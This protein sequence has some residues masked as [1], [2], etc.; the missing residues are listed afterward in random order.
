MRICLLIVP[1]HGYGHGALSLTLPIRKDRKTNQYTTKVFMKTPLQPIK[2]L[3]DLGSP[4]SWVDCLKTYKPQSYKFYMCNPQHVCDSLGSSGTELY[5]S[6]DCSESG[7][8]LG[9]MK[10]NT[11]T[12]LIS[13]FA[14][15][16]EFV[17]LVKDKLAIL[18]PPAQLFINN[19]TFGCGDSVRF[20]YRVAKGVVGS[21]ALGW[22][23]L[24]LAAQASAALST[25]STNS[26]FSLCLPSSSHKAKGFAL[27]GSLRGAP[28]R[29]STPSSGV[30]DLS[31]S[32]S[33]VPLLSKLGHSR[34]PLL[35]YELADYYV[36]LTSIK[37][38]GKKVALD[39]Y[40]WSTFGAFGSPYGGTKISTIVPY[41]KMIDYVYEGFTAAFVK[42]AASAM[43]L[44]LMHE[45]VEPFR[46]CYSAKDVAITSGGPAVPT[47]D[48]VFQISNHKDVQ[49]R[50]NGSHSM[51]RVKRK[52]GD[53]AWCLAFIDSL[54]GITGDD[55]TASII[56]GG[57]Q[58]EDHLLLKH[59]KTNQYTTSVY[60]KT[61]LQLT[62]L[63]VDLEASFSWMDCSNTY[64]S[65]SYQH[66]PCNPDRVC[67]SLGLSCYDC[68]EPLP[69]P[70][71]ANNSCT[72]SIYNPI[73]EEG[74]TGNALRD[75][76]AFP[77]TTGHGSTRGP[78]DGTT[79]KNYTF[80]CAP[81][82]SLKV[83]PKG[84][85]GTASLGWF[86][87]SLR[88]QVISSSSSSSNSFALCL[89]STRKGNGVAV[90]GSTGPYK[91]F[92][93]GTDLSKAL[94]Y[95]PLIQHPHWQPQNALV[96][97]RAEEYF[98]GL[99]SIE[100]NGKAVPLD[101]TL[102]DIDAE[103]GRGGT[104]LTTV[105]PYTRMRTSIYKNVTDAF[106]KEMNLSLAAEPV[107]PFEFCYPAKDVAMTG[108]G[109][110][111]VP[112]IDLVF[113]SKDVKWR[114]GG[115]NSLVR[116]VVKKE[117]KVVDLWCLG[118]IDAGEWVDISIV[119]GGH[120]LEDNLLQF[121]LQSKRLGFSSS[122]LSK[123]TTCTNFNFNLNLNPGGKH[124]Y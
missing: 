19:Y 51:V 60:I 123:G 45:P 41:T 48:L 2:L 84:V 97:G 91:F 4:L 30:I 94:T 18:P 61:P 102:L 37:I 122:L 110:P 54:D 82:Y 78:L 29:F 47:I 116:V 89:P 12:G 8:R 107:K 92:P 115:G 42:E 114:M 64:N 69:G 83:L 70:G 9:C 68:F 75:T 79:L 71:C 17:N 100:I 49:W 21:A 39:E 50:I 3:L 120:Q 59:S 31:K 36:G 87:L 44:T 53:D 90:I 33:Y 76:L 46:F 34:N 93:A 81:S 103:T 113:Q 106:V 99:S 13:T 32:L 67:Q 117:E 15:G 14:Q 27:I 72:F 112:A 35:R 80:G 56:L 11:C 77:A 101:K 108:E 58:V 111:A 6:Q 16:T 5:C 65:T 74:Y 124:A 85:V 63:L 25:K 26:S 7:Q 1:L 86:N 66:Y 52:G 119:V 57:Y 96:F 73:S 55:G 28:Y 88:A 40:G 24:S 10:N 98:V 118:F 38:N 104:K 95:T 109:V 43:N 121:D 20:R 105:V 62:K 23:P 22:Y